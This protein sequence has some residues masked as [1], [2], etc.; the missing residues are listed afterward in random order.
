M[1]GLLV[2]KRLRMEGFIVL[3][4]E[5]RYDEAE[6][7]LARMVREGRLKYREDIVEGL[8]AAPAALVRVLAGGNIGKAMVR[9]D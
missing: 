1:P 9:V 8:A 4:Y 2:V 6:A 5:S 3:D 7:D